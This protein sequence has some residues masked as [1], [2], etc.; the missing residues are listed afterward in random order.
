METWRRILLIYI[1][2]QSIHSCATAPSYVAF[3]FL[4]SVC[5]IHVILDNFT[6]WCT[7]IV[8]ASHWL[9]PLG[10]SRCC[11]CVFIE[12]YNKYI[13]LFGYPVFYFNFTNNETILPIMHFPDII[14]YE[15]TKFHIKESSITHIKSNFMIF[16]TLTVL[17]LL[18]T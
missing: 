14:T 17:A 5:R 9:K 3:I 1:Y 13:H 18:D 8:S 2:V 7:A 4:F 11:D 16:P 6:I 12:Q 15:E 10:R